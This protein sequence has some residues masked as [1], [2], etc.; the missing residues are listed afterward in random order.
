MLGKISKPI[1]LFVLIVSLLSGCVYRKTIPFPQITVSAKPTNTPVS[2]LVFQDVPSPLFFD[3]TSPCCAA[4]T[5]FEFSVEPAL[6]QAFIT[7]LLSAGIQAAAGGKD[8]PISSYGYTVQAEFFPTFAQM[9]ACK[10]LAR[11]PK[12]TAYSP[13]NAHLRLTIHRADNKETIAQ[14]EES[15]PVT[16]QFSFSSRSLSAL[17][18]FTFGLFTPIQMQAMGKDLSVQLQAAL[19]ELI[20]KIIIYIQEDKQS[21]FSSAYAQSE[22]LPPSLGKYRQLLQSVARLKNPAGGEEGSAFFIT[23]NGYLLTASSLVKNTH[24]AEITPASGNKPL[25]AYVQMRNTARGIALL[26]AEGENYIPLPLETQNPHAFKGEEVIS[27]GTGP[28]PLTQGILSGV[29]RING[30]RYLL[31]DTAFV[32]THTGGPLL[33]ADGASVLGVNTGPQPPAL[34]QA[35]SVFELE[36]IFPQIIKEIFPKSTSNAS[37]IHPEAKNYVK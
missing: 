7:G 14:Y 11:Y 3:C 4:Y 9:Q 10:P 36:K 6:S 21:F 34:S 37:F 22:D 15:L 12:I 29:S 33:K 20:S 24:W 1:L 13:F 32:A 26:K 8:T 2:M 28:S 18:P 27:L 25:R 19:Q 5:G 35:V 17:A 30:T 16:P 31:A 23:Q